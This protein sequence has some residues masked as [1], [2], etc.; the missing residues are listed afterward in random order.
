MVPDHVYQ[1]TSHEAA[2]A[3]LR[4]EQL[5]LTNLRY[6]NDMKE[7]WWVYDQL[8]AYLAER[9]KDS[10]PVLK[11]VADR[12]IADSQ[13]RNRNISICVTCFSAEPDDA[14]Q[15][16]RYAQEGKGVAIGFHTEG[17]RK[18]LGLHHGEADEVIY[19][20]ASCRDRL[21]SAIRALEAAEREGRPLAGSMTDPLPRIATFTKEPSFA[22]EREFRVALYGCA[23]T[24][25]QFRPRIDTLV[26][27][28]VLP[29]KRE[30]IS[31]IRLGPKSAIESSEAWGVAL[32][33]LYNGAQPDVRVVR[34]ESGLR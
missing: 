26:P 7:F 15:W 32:A 24:T 22:S 11:S 17:L 29:I 33:Q 8:G 16:Q 4:N 14:S 5:W 25:Y 13:R 20:V 2:L 10:D 1:Y 19:G 21:D 9:A 12:V 28:V 30:C 31:E 34:S 18:A 6:L 23:Y 3:I 27:Y